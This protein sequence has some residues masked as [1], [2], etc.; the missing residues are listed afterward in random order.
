MKKRE[1][2]TGPV[3]HYTIG[4][5]ISRIG[6]VKVNPHHPDC[7]AADVKAVLPKGTYT[8]EGRI[9]FAEKWATKILQDA[10]LPADPKAAV[11]YERDGVKWR[12]TALSSLEAE[13]RVSERWYAAEILSE[14]HLVRT[15]IERGETADTAHR[16]LDL[17]ML[18]RELFDVMLH[19]R[20]VLKWEGWQGSGSA[21]GSSDK[22]IRPLVEWLRHT[23]KQYPDKPYTNY[24]NSLPDHDEGDSPLRKNGAEMLRKGGVLLVNYNDG[25]SRSLDRSSFRRYVADVKESLKK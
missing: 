6:M 15:L 2:K 25:R 21:G 8:F 18:L 22:K 24:W 20:K 11:I 13:A 19:N 12:G 4:E 17:G 10:G 1:K 9:A 16:S 5:G 3:T 23:V 14:L 7:T